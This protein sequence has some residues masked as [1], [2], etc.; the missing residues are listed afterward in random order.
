[1]RETMFLVQVP[2]FSSLGRA[3][4]NL[5][6]VQG[7]RRSRQCKADSSEARPGT[8]RWISWIPHLTTEADGDVVC[9]DAHLG[10]AT[11]RQYVSLSVSR[12][13]VGS[14]TRM[15]DILPCCY[16]CPVITLPGIK[17]CYTYLITSQPQSRPRC[18]SDLVDWSKVDAG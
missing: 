5:Q 1:M 4:P 3:K 8:G 12:H 6:G 18:P 13:T 9:N 17:L 16:N 7:P 14:L 15:T 2:P 10:E 11:G